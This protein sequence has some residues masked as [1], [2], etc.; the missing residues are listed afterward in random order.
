[1]HEKRHLPL[2]LTCLFLAAAACGCSA[3]KSVLEKMSP[4]AL[5][6]KV[7]PAKYGLKK[8]VL[9]IPLADE[10]GIG[11]TEIYRINEMFVQQ[12]KKSPR[13]VVYKLSGRLPLLGDELPGRTAGITDPDL[14]RKVRKL[15]MNALVAGSVNPVET[16]TKKGP[17]W[18][19]PFRKV[20]TVYEVTT[21][22]TVV[23]V[24]SGTLLLSRRETEKVSLR[25]E[26]ARDRD[27]KEVMAAVLKKAVSGMLQRH[28]RAIDKKLAAEPWTGRILSMENGEITINAGNKVGVHPGQVFNVF[29]PGDRI[30]CKDG[31][32]LTVLGKKIGAIK[33][34]QVMEKSAVASPVAKADFSAGLVVRERP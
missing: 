14:L 22:V 27:P 5:A 33:I 21:E 16:R 15:D 2:I 13:L 24:A 19:W 30:V 12:L 34:T 31:K 17:F 10:A 32:T 3:T 11:E 25:R 8:Q 1:M 23:D 6:E 4:K 28:A 20:Y 9:V 7:M 18:T 29:A 26:E